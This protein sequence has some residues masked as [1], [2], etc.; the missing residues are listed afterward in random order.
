[1]ILSKLG[2]HSKGRFCTPLW[3]SGGD[4]DGEHLALP[5]IP[6]IEHPR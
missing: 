1:M 6:Y 2:G 5:Y 4:V 3:T